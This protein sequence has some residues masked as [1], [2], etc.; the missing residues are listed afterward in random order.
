MPTNFLLLRFPMETNASLP[1]WKKAIPFLNWMPVYKKKMLKPDIIAGITLASF[2]LPGSMAYAGLAGLPPQAGIYCYIFG[3]LAFALFTTSKH[4]AI[5]PISSISLLVGTTLAGLS[6]SDPAK[7][8][9]MASLT[10]LGVGIIALIAY[11]IK[12][13]SLVNFI[14]ETIL[15]GFKAGAAFSIASTV[16]P[17]LMGV[18]GGGSNFFARI[19]HVMRHIGD[20]NM[21]VLVFGLII[22]ILLLAGEKWL[23]GK[24]VSLVIVIASIALMAFTG[25]SGLGIK[26]IGS[27]PAGLPSFQLP[28]LGAGEMATVI[29][30]AFA[31]FVLG[32]IETVSAARSLAIDHKYEIDVRQELISMGAANISVSLFGGYPVAGGLSQSAVNEKAGA[33]SPVSIITCSLVLILLLLFFTGLLKHLPKVLLSAIVLNAILGLFK[34]K[35]LKRLYYL[36]RNEFLVAMVALGGVLIF[37]ILKGVMIAAL[38]SLLMVIQKASRPYIARLGRIGNTHRFTDIKRHPD[39]VLLPGIVILRIEAS[40]FYFNAQYVRDQILEAVNNEVSP[41]RLVLLDL[42]A[43]PWVDVSGSKMLLE[44]SKTLKQRSVE[45]RIVE[46][47]AAVRDMLR[48]QGLENKIGHISRKVTIDDVITDFLE[49]EKEVLKW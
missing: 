16:L 20:T 18:T 36:N 15:L 2:V 19:S 46:A 35:E 12:L 5:G 42:S 13:S 31:C 7:W 6:D 26:T 25:L 37:G 39:N 47:L 22:F 23:S 49:E 24:P 45:C 34:Y 30:L 27:I 44:L 1:F 11:L 3:G 17:D 32:Y 33:K 21:A 14:G 10:A 28:V 40:I 29:D 48:K 38:L 9:V 8:M 41:A 4:V 43:T